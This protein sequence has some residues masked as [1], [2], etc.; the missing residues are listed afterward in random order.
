MKMAPEAWAKALFRRGQVELA[1]WQWFSG[2]GKDVE[3]APIF[4]GR[5][6]KLLELDR[7]DA[8]PAGM[9][10]VPA[11]RYAF[12]DRR[13]A[14]RG[15][16]VAFRPFNA[17]CLAVAIDLLDIGFKQS[18]VVFLLRHIR[19]ELEARFSTVMVYPPAV[20]MK[21][22]DDRRLFMGL[23]R[24]ELTEQFPEATRPS[25]PVTLHPTFSRFAD[26]PAKL[27]ANLGY[28]NRSLIVIELAETAV[29]VTRYLHQAPVVKRGRPSAE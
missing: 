27:L 14:G 25:G 20:G 29:L 23:R 15:T 21:S 8:V 12:H 2:Y 22:E 10:G 17:F 7:G 6:K 5:I 19:L 4:I 13:P 16:E 28:R 24:V 3:P 9:G 18:E 11:A 26:G 1:L